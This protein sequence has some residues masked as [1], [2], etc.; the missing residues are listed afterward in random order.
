MYSCYRHL[1]W[2]YSARQ[3]KSAPPSPVRDERA[4]NS[5]GHHAH[6]DR[7]EPMPN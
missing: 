2:S 3:A 7:R 6:S 4:Q 5:G 1:Q